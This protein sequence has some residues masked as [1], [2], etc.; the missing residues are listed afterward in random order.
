MDY[1]SKSKTVYI[2]VKG[3]ARRIPV[4][5]DEC[6]AKKYKHT[7]LHYSKL[8]GLYRIQDGKRCY[9]AREILNLTAPWT[10]VNFTSTNKLD[11]RKQNLTCYV[12]PPERRGK[13][14]VHIPVTA[15]N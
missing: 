11:M 9:T 7:R 4:I 2:R 1:K 10:W 12:V 13:Y 14:C 15:L 6:D 8:H 3:K 5:F